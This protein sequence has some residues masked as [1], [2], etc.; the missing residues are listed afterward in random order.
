VFLN[1]SVR[2]T[3]TSLNCQIYLIKSVLYAEVTKVEY[4][5]LYILEELYGPAT[6]NSVDFNIILILSIIKR[7]ICAKFFQPLK[8]SDN[9]NGQ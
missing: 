3:I 4:H 7:Y 6:T 2:T 1:N 5:V 9:L 8:M